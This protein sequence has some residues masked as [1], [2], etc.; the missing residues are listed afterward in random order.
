M[1]H[2]SNVGGKLLS[3]VGGKVFSGTGVS[4][5]PNATDPAINTVIIIVFIVLYSSMANNATI[6]LT[7]R[8]R[9][10]K[11]VESTNYDETITTAK[12]EVVNPVLNLIHRL[13]AVVDKVVLVNVGVVVHRHKCLISLITRHH[14]KDIGTIYVSHKHINVSIKTLLGKILFNFFVIE[15]ETVYLYRLFLHFNNYL[16]LVL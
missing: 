10:L 5:L 13:V 3:Q 8:F 12:G 9:Y 1:F 16:K 7:T 11:I 2:S 6:Y 15:L 14:V 4:E